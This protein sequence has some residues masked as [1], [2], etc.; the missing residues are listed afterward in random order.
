M[1]IRTRLTNQEGDGEN[2]KDGNDNTG[3]GDN[4]QD[5]SDETGFKGASSWKGAGEFSRFYH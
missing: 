5:P 2:G 3:N 4:L 1:F